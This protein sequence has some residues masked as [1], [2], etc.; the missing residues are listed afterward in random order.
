[1][2]FYDE[3]NWVDWLMLSSALQKAIRRGQ[4]DLAL[5]FAKELIRRGFASHVHKR[6]FVYLV[7]DIWW[8]NIWLVYLVDKF[9]VKKMPTENELLQLVW[10]FSQSKKNRDVHNIRVCKKHKLV[11]FDEDLEN[12]LKGRFSYSILDIKKLLTTNSNALDEYLDKEGLFG[13][14]IIQEN[15]GKEIYQ[16]ITLQIL[17]LSQYLLKNSE[18]KIISSYLSVIKHLREQQVWFDIYFYLIMLWIVKNSNLIQN[19]PVSLLDFDLNKYDFE[20][21]YRIPDY[22]IDMHT[23]KWKILGKTEKDF[24]LEWW[25]IEN[26]I[27]LFPQDIY[28]SLI[29][30]NLD[31]I[32]NS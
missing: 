10:I 30:K 31:K 29:I 11:S 21:L 2:K 20:K 8:G 32:T 14:K 6:L 15:T 4:V 13:G 22:A 19:K 18:D 1:M 7:E 3:I 5:S 27:I 28:Y 25:I 12:I 9:L 24:W 23:K 16:K 26:K 17:E